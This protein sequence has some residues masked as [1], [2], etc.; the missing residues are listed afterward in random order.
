M[1]HTCNLF[2]ADFYVNVVHIYCISQATHFELCILSKWSL[3]EKFDFKIF[4][5]NS[6]NIQETISHTVKVF[7]FKLVDDRRGINDTT[8]IR[9]PLRAAFVTGG[10]AFYRDI[11]G[12]G[13]TSCKSRPGNGCDNATYTRSHTER[14]RIASHH[15]PCEIS[16]FV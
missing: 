1:I 2:F 8:R 6:Q 11:S 3:I 10:F 14:T 13:L 4:F 7:F 16:F 5:E 15:I 12:L 9:S